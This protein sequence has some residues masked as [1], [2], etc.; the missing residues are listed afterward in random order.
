MAWLWP[1]ALFALPLAV[2]LGVQAWRIFV[3]VWDAVMDV[4]IHL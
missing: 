2:W 4:L 3:V 1:L